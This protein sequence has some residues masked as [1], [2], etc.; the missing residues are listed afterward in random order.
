M[1]AKGKFYEIEHQTPALLQQYNRS[2]ST[3]GSYGRQKP[4][5]GECV[6]KIS[7]IITPDT[8][9]PLNLKYISGPVGHNAIP[10]IIFMNLIKVF[11]YI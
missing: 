10:G 3:T 1:S 8:E 4:V 6:H 7:N 9:L 2:N 11:I 5:N